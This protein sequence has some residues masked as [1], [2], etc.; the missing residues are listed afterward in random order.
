MTINR[1]LFLI[2]ILPTITILLF[3]A[4]HIIDKYNTYNTHEHL[5]SSST[6]IDNTA[7]VLHE[8]QIERGLISSYI[9]NINTNDSLYFSKLLTNQ[10]KKTDTVIKK[11]DIFL[12]DLDKNNLKIINKKFTNKITFLLNS[13]KGLR[14]NITNNSMTPYSIFLYFSYINSQLLELAEGIKFYSNDE[15]TQN[16]IM[17]LKK[18]LI[19]QEISGQ[20]RGL[21]A[22][23]NGKKISPVTLA[24]LNSIWTIQDSAYENI[25]IILHGSDT[26]NKLDIL[27]KNKD[28]LY[29]QKVKQLI[30]NSSETE[31]NIN[32]KT[33][34][35][36]TTNR[37][38]DYH[39]LG[40]YIF[41]KIV[42][43]IKQKNEELYNSFIYQIII[44]ITAIFSLLLGAF[45]LSRDI[46]KSL[47][48][49][50]R[51]MDKFFDFLN[52]KSDAP[53]EIMIDSKDEISSMANKI[54]K[55]MRYLL[56]NL[57]NDKNF[58]NE[59]TQIVTQMKDGDFS[60]KPYSEPTNPSLIKLKLVFNELIKLISD[61][62]SQQT[63]SLETLNKTLEDK[64]HFQTAELE[65]KIIEITQ[66]RDTAIDAQNAKDEFLA[67]ISHEIR[68]P[69]NAILGFVT[70]LS[71]R[72]KDDK[73]LDYLHIIDTSGKSLLT[74]INDILDFSKIQSGK[75]TIT[76]HDIDPMKEFSDCTLLFTSKAYEKHLTYAVYIDPNLPKTITV[77]DTRVKQIIS[78]LL[79]NAIK[80]TPQDG[81]VKVNISID[82]N[83]LIVLVQDSGIGIPKERQK[84]IFNPFSQADNSTTRK[85]GGTGLGLSISCK[86]SKLMSASL[87]LTSKENIGSTFRLIVPI[88]AIDNSP[89]ELLDMNKIKK[90]RFA[91]LNTSQ[92]DEIF[93][94]LIKKYLSDFGISN[95]IELNEFTKEGYD[96]LFFIPNDSYNDDIIEAE[97]A[98]IAMLKSNMINL[99]N[100]TNI[101]SLYA[102]F[103]PTSV[104]QAID[105]ITVENIQKITKTVESDKNKD[106]NDKVKFS[107]FVLV[108][109]DNKT[110]QLLI[111]LILDDYDIKY[112]I[113]EDGKQAV[114]LFKQKKFDLVLMDE[115]MPELNGLGAMK[116]I[117]EYE[118]KNKLNKTPIVALTANTLTSDVTKFFKEGMDGFVAK[119][120]NNDL[121]EE[122]LHKHL[123]RL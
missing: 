104:I 30:R 5:L 87:T 36:T 38:N 101:T 57:E 67:N 76:P 72:I 69:L 85:Y 113:V 12:K 58:I 41:S 10:Q 106:N 73:S 99:A 19:F 84:E 59:T 42:V 65:K 70:I 123:K 107:G 110:N 23:Q 54:N 117:K 13:I 17:I 22:L 11:I 32:S 116:Q 56:L 27:D 43:N 75:F 103:A 83:S 4:N 8:I 37:I 77:D 88:I 35:K 108:A 3:S 26:Y 82:D 1:K 81:V 44:T 71:K 52:F 18:L 50:D 45:L 89:K 91:I 47:K 93:A 90:Y 6:L 122:E 119:P 78:N 102:P 7:N 115:N 51:G 63:K 109:E 74:I 105:D 9:N 15:K 31:F 95:V 97:I 2:T 46:D 120:I 64:V 20:E 94:R 25:K 24:K 118:M 21:V 29:I 80:F 48:R 60:E 100:H 53:K 62:I 68:T 28:N 14:K 33:W 112:N 79:S 40:R 96:I 61:K 92:E 114:E 86:L 98:A 49:L 55:Q 39:L 34:F 66:A 121:F 16:N 111:S